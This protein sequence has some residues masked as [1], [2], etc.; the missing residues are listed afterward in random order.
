MTGRSFKEVV[1]SL[2]PGD[3]IQITAAET[4]MRSVVLR[5]G[6]VANEEIYLSLFLPGK[7]C[8]ILHPASPFCWDDTVGGL[9]DRAQRFG[10]SEVTDVFK[11][12]GMDVVREYERVP[13]KEADTRS[14]DS[15][16]LLMF[17]TT[18]EWG[19]VACGLVNNGEAGSSD[20]QMAL[21]LKKIGLE[22]SDEQF[23]ALVSLLELSIRRASMMSIPVLLLPSLVDRFIGD[24]DFDFGGEVCTDTPDAHKN[25]TVH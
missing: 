17:M 7:L 11:G 3:V 12:T 18:A 20:T 1:A 24:A 19:K 15:S 16:D 22:A 23:T 8:F 5:R 25:G 14:M 13:R 6:G 2:V 21:L 4:P 9:V 10:V